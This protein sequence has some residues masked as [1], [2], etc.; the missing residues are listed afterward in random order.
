[1]GFLKVDL[2]IFRICLITVFF[3]LKGKLFSV[4]LARKVGRYVTSEIKFGQY[5]KV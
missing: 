4:V 2:E 3:A 1:M 5:F